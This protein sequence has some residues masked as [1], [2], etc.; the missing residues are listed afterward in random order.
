MKL[1]N[2]LPLDPYSFIYFAKILFAIM[3][4][5]ENLLSRPE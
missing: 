3:D 4:P 5:F 1:V 2:S